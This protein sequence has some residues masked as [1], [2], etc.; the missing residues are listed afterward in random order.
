MASHGP[1]ASTATRSRSTDSASSRSHS[2]SVTP[3]CGCDSARMARRDHHLTAA[4]HEPADDRAA[5]RPATTADDG[6]PASPNNHNASSW[7]EGPS[8]RSDHAPWL[9]PRRPSSRSWWSGWRGCWSPRNAAQ[10]DPS[11]VAAGAPAGGG[12]AE[13]VAARPHRPRA[14]RSRERGHHRGGARERLRGVARHRLD[15]RQP[16]RRRHQRP[17]HQRRRHAARDRPRRSHARRPCGARATP[18]VDIAML[19]VTGTLAGTPLPI[20]ARA[21]SERSR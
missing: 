16:R 1:I 19:R 5:E 21:L 4:G 2:I 15:L 10:I 7:I 11:K 8:R 6:D 13:P 3:S 20:D 9:A 17:R 14:R 12:H 18:T